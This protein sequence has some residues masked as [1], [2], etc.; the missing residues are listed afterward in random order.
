[1]TARRFSVAFLTEGRS[2]FPDGDTDVDGQTGQK[3]W[4]GIREQHMGG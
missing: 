2:V 1:M 4:S 3:G